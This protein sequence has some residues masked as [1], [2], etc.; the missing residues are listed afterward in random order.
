M[1]R[2]LR[3]VWRKKGWRVLHSEYLF[4]DRHQNL[5]RCSLGELPSWGSQFL[6]SSTSVYFE[7]KLV[8]NIPIWLLWRRNHTEGVFIWFPRFFLRANIHFNFRFPKID[9]TKIHHCSQ[10]CS[11]FFK[12]VMSRWV[13]IPLIDLNFFFEEKYL[14]MVFWIRNYSLNFC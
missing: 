2:F 7:A 12:W 9:L 4:L 13:E 6:R 11:A 14:S 8:L 3:F 1:G 10:R 5:E